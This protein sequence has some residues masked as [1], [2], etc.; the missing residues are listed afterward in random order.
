MLSMRFSILLNWRVESSSWRAISFDH[1][2]VFGSACGRVDVE[3][4]FVV[5]FEV[6]DDA[7]GDEFEVTFR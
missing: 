7:S 1:A 4:G 2:L 6:L 3:F 5:A